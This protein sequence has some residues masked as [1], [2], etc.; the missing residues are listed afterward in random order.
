[1]DFEH[2]RRDFPIED[3]MAR[4]GCDMTH[5]GYMYRAPYREDRNPSMHV[6]RVRYVWCDYGLTRSDGT[7]MGGGNIELVRMVE[8]IDSNRAAAERILELFREIDL[9]LTRPARQSTSNY[10]RDEPAIQVISTLN[11]IMSGS[12]KYYLQQR[13]IN[14]QLASRWC[15]E[16]DFRIDRTGKRLFAIGFPNDRGQWALRN[17][18]YKGSTGQGV[19][20]IVKGRSIVGPVDSEVLQYF[21]DA[22]K[23][24]VAVFEGFFDYLSWLTLERTTDAPCDALV[25][26][27]TSNVA[28]AI[29]F[30]SGHDSVECWLDNDDAGRQCTQVIRDRC[31][32]SVIEDMS[33][34]YSRY[35]DLNDWLVCETERLEQGRSQSKGQSL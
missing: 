35:N 20:T 2:V 29:P 7:P 14:P 6:D 12:L 1:M 18:F 21:P 5:R 28:E 3:L 23:G 9:D 30:L 25:L 33:P 31:L 19:S 11:M 27:S 34:R 16:V 8:N 22:G 17:S 13:C 26:N 10:H 15:H 24:R 32:D 4:M